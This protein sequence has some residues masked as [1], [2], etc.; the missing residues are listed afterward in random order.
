MKST[1]WVDLLT[2][3]LSLGVVSLA[4]GWMFA[5]GVFNVALD[6]NTNLVW[7]FIRSAG[8]IAYVL[9]AVSMVWGLFAGSHLVRDWSPGPVSL[10]MHSTISWLALLLG[11][12][13]SLLLLFDTYL[14]FTLT[15]IFVPFTGTYRPEFVGLGIIGFWVLLAVSISFPL[16]R[17][18]GYRNWKLLH[19]TSYLAFGLISA[20]GLLA[21]TDG[22]RLGV[23]LL[24]GLGLAAMLLLLGLRTA[25]PQ[26]AR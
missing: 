23:R 8:I 13:H 20:H 21:G 10:T 24:I 7:Y 1:K 25:I 6:T 14:P 2:V 12:V 4:V 19:Y 5:S 9:L 11:L 3:G 15:Q 26:N 18:L 22:E 16:K 17:K